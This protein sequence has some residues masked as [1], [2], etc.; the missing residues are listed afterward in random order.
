MAKDTLFVNTKHI[1]RL[2]IELKGFPKEVGEATRLALNRTIDHIITKSGQ[3]VPKYYAIKGKEVK[4]SFNGGIHRP[5]KTNLS[6]SVVSVG[7]TLSFAHFPYTPKTPKRGGKSIFQN[8]VMVT[9]KKNKGKVLSRTGFVATT[10]A[11][12]EDKTQFNVWQRLGKRRLP[13]APIRTL[14]IPQMI[15]AEGIDKQILE[16]AEKKLQERLE[17]EIMRQM[18][19]MDKNIKG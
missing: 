8:A 16:A 4:E 13:I 12:S 18:T 17:H 2:A 7:H 11:K 19:T 3:L 6:A 14:S 9:I 1:D 5:S 10:G 15:T